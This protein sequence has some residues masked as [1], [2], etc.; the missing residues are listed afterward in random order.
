[1]TD[2]PQTC[3]CAERS[4]IRAPWP[5]MGPWHDPGCELFAETHGI[6]AEEALSG[7]RYE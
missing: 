1:M 4:S 5:Y 6:T 7:E 3:P 2:W